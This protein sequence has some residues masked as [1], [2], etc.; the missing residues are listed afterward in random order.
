MQLYIRFSNYNCFLSSSIKKSIFFFF[1][2]ISQPFFAQNQEKD[3]P[4]N[5]LIEACETLKD[6]DEKSQ[7]FMAV[8]KKAKKEKNTKFLLKG[9]HFLALLYNNEKRI[10][11]CDTLIKISAKTPSIKYPTAPY[12]I[13]GSYFFRKNNFKKAL[14]N[15]LSANRYARLYTNEEY[16]IQSNYYVAVLKNRIGEHEEALKL[17]LDNYKRIKS[18]KKQVSDYNYL[19]YL[20]ALANTYNDLKLTDSASYYNKIGIK[21]SIKRKNE[22][23]RFHFILN[24]GVTQYYNKQFQRSL[25]SINKALPYF[26]NIDDKQN[27]AVGYFYK[28]KI[29]LKLNKKEKAIRMF[30]KVDTVF[31]ESQYV[32]PKLRQTYEILI[33]HYSQNK[34]I[35]QRLSYVTRLL[36]LDSILNDNE[37]YI[38]SKI[39]KEYDTSNLLIEKEKIINKLET[40]KAKTK[41]IVFTLLALLFATIF[42]FYYQYK[43]RQVYKLRFLKLFKEDKG[44]EN[45]DSLIEVSK[46]NK[47]NSSLNISSDIIEDILVKLNAFETKQ[48][49]L[50]KG[51]NLGDL[52][53]E[54]KTNANYLS[55]IVNHYKKQSFINYLNELRINF[56]IEKI[57]ADSKFRRYT[58][59]AIAQ[60]VGFS[61]T[62]SFSKAF[63]TKTGIIPSYFI[64]ELEKITTDS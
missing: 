9:Y 25:D 41:Y 44:K 49:Y 47:P 4:Y 15:Y 40:S 20:F 22:K 18:N 21:E 56:A 61:N 1:I 31:I 34:D 3:K 33:N 54:L 53:K 55:K 24:E 32:L 11:Y 28:G 37:L 43:K 16:I 60:D 13:K 23:K 14:D 6:I 36:K 27:S 29:F 51:I 12:L 46:E 50:K 39:I 59:K 57:K 58:I 62:Q 63:F 38:N 26:E 2:C 42:A 35:S 10:L 30:K 8:V 19:T 17:H 52:A 48:G 64:K 5:T 7:C 45:L